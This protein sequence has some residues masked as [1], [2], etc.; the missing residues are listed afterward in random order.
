[1]AAVL[2]D[3]SVRVTIASSAVLPNNL[4]DLGVLGALHGTVTGLA[5]QLAVKFRV[6][7]KDRCTSRAGEGRFGLRSELAVL[8]GFLRGGRHVRIV[9]PVLDSE[10]HVVHGHA[11]RI[12]GLLHIVMDIGAQETFGDMDHEDLVG[13]AFEFETSVEHHVEIVQDIG[14]V[15][16]GQSLLVRLAEHR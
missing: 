9:G 16:I 6:S 3:S 14:A 11:V 1:M 10:D 4:G 15:R 8:L 2:R 12:H 13:D 5:A 7:T